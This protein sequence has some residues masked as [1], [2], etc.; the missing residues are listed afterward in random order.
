M[1]GVFCAKDEMT[2]Y[3]SAQLIDRLAPLLSLPAEIARNRSLMRSATAS[4]I[5]A[6]VGEMAENSWL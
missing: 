4:Q 2:S 1:A 3:K 5:L 6:L